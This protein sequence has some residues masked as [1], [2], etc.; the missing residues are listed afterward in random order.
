MTAAAVPAALLALLVGAA[1]AAAAAAVP[2]HAAARG[3]GANLNA[4]SS[5]KQTAEDKLGINLTPIKGLGGSTVPSSLVG[6]YRATVTG[7]VQ[8]ELMS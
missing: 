4:G 2:P 6:F 7:Q 8:T 1:A 5:D 3:G